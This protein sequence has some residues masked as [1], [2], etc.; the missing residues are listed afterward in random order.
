[1]EIVSYII[2]GVYAIAYGEAIMEF[3]LNL[4]EEVAADKAMEKY[5]KNR[6][7]HNN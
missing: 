6:Q 4:N 3:V 5:V 1:M 2:I 7:I